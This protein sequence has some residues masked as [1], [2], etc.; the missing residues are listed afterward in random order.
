MA[1][2]IEKPTANA[3]RDQSPGDIL[4]EDLTGLEVETGSSLDNEKTCFHSK[5]LNDY[6][7]FL[8]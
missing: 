5:Y 6:L 8:L 3:S 2:L 1:T 7:N 4:G